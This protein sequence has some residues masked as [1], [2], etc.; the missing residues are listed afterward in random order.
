M[1]AMERS[2]KFQNHSGGRILARN[3]GD[4]ESHGP[5]FNGQSFNGK[6][7]RSVGHSSEPPEDNFRNALTP[8]GSD[9]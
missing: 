5:S 7:I 3:E 8:D 4:H 2:V 9:A 6:M 1:S